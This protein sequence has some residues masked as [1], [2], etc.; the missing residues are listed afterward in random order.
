[1]NPGSSVVGTGWKSCQN[2]DGGWGETVASYDDPSLRGKG[3]STPS[4]SAWALLG[5]CAFPTGESPERR[6]RR[7]LS[8][9]YSKSGW[10]LERNLD[11]R[12]RFPAGFLSQIRHVPEQLAAD[13]ARSVRRGSFG[14]ST[15]IRDTLSEMVSD[16]Q[17]DSELQPSPGSG[18][19]FVDLKL[20]FS[21]GFRVGERFADEAES[22]ISPKSWWQTRSRRKGSNCWKVE[23][24]FSLT[25]KRG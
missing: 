9:F 20:C 3:V 11:Y 12:N 22:W 13:G 2:E 19:F 6:T 23:G 14:E 1:M 4:Q 18:V 5:L 21:A 8:C 10:F 7:A 17:R 25:L 24:S 15:R 16:A